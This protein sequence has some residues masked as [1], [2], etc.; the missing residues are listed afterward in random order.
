MLGQV[1]K[2]GM[3]CHAMTFQLS[4]MLWSRPL[5]LSIQPPPHL[6]LCLKYWNIYT[7]GDACETLICCFCS[8]VLRRNWMQLD[9]LFL[10]AAA[11]AEKQPAV[12]EPFLLAWVPTCMRGPI[13]SCCCWELTF[14]CWWWMSCWFKR[15]AG[16]AKLLLNS[17]LLLLMNHYP[18]HRIESPQ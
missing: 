10:L 4:Y 12:Y 16:F 9:F 5:K 7:S 17:L 14:D 18:P 13:L 1:S 2:D 3:S 6:R 15:D 8:V 11:V